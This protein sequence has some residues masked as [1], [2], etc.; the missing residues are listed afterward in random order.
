LPERI[1][2]DMT[3]TASQKLATEVANSVHDVLPDT[4]VQVVGSDSPPGAWA[5][6][7][8]T[9]DGNAFQFFGEAGVW[10]CVHSSATDAPRAT[11]IEL[12]ASTNKVVVAILNEFLISW[13]DSEAKTHPKGDSVTVSELVS[14]I[15]VN[16]NFTLE[17]LSADKAYAYI[18]DATMKFHGETL[19]EAEY[20]RAAARRFGYGQ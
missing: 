7:I 17:T 8:S 10:Q 16:R 6:Q 11:D 9:F 15:W 19:D 18:I 3:D 20:A 14:D 2:N 4:K 5:V 1:Q 13:H 12:D